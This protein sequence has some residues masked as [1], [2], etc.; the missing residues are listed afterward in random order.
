MI[1]D[2]FTIHF[3]TSA[4]SIFTSFYANVSSITLGAAQFCPRLD[5]MYVSSIH[6]RHFNWQPTSGRPTRRGKMDRTSK[7]RPNLVNLIPPAYFMSF[8][9][10]CFVKMRHWRE[11]ERGSEHRMTRGIVVTVKFKALKTDSKVQVALRN[12]NHFCVDAA[13]SQAQYPYI[14]QSYHWHQFPFP[15]R[16]NTFSIRNTVAAPSLWT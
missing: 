7:H 16:G 6:C 10:I 4:R 13:V 11:R 12:H 8:R 1:S 9:S 3:C 15:W 5:H 2:N 14:T